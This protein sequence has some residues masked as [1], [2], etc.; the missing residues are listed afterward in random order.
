MDPIELPK[1]KELERFLETTM[2]EIE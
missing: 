2:K 1:K